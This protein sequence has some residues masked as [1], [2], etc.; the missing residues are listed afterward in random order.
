MMDTKIVSHLTPESTQSRQSLTDLHHPIDH[1]SFPLRVY[2]T[3]GLADLLYTLFDVAV[4][5]CH[6]LQA[7]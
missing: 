4:T 2:L 7:L 6:A 3:K 1:Q 5:H